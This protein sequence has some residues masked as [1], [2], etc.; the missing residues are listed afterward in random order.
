MTISDCADRSAQP[1]PRGW[2]LVV[3]DQPNV[4]RTLAAILESDGY[5]VRV[6]TEA[7]A[8]LDHLR[9][10]S[11]DVIL[12]ELHLG[13]LD[14]LTLL[15]EAR[16]R[17]PDTLAILTTGQASVESAVQALRGGAYDYLPKPSPVDELRATVARAMEQRH[18]QR[19]IEARVQDLER[20]NATVRALNA[21]LE[22]R[23][24][25]ATT[26]LEGRL[27]ALRMLSEATA[28]LASSLEYHA[29]LQR[30]VRVAV[31]F[32]ADWS[33]FDLVDD[34]GSARG[35]AVAHADPAREPSL[36][37]IQRLYPPDTHGPQPVSEVLR[38]G[39]SVLLAEVSEPVLRETS[40]D[41]KHLALRRR[42]GFRSV[43]VVPL[44]GRERLL[45]A[46]T[47][48]RGGSRARF[49]DDDRLL[50]E[51]L[52]HRCATALD[53][54]RLYE[55]VRRHAEH[56]EVLA[57]SAQAFAASLEL[58]DVLA[59][60]ARAGVEHLGDGCLVR[61]NSDGD[62]HWLQA[63]AIEH[64]NPHRQALAREVLGGAPARLGEGLSGTVAETGRPLL[65]NDLRSREPPAPLNVPSGDAWQRLSA[66]SLLIVP[67]RNK[68]GVIGTLET[69]RD[70]SSAPYTTD[71]QTFL[72]ALADRAALA[73]TN[74]RLHAE[75]E[76]ALHMRDEF[77]AIAA[78]ELKTPLTALTAAAQLSLR[79]FHGPSLPEVGQL[80]A[81]LTTIE[82]QARRFGA[83]VDRLLQVSTLESAPLMLRRRPTDVVQLVRRGLERAQPR[84]DR[85][86]VV[87]RAP[88]RVVVEMD[89][90]WM[91]RVVMNLVEN[92]LKYSAPAGTVEIDIEPR[93]AGEVEIAVRDHGRGI[94][95]ERRGHL[96]ERYYR[97]HADDYAS[98]LGLGLSI[99]R[100][101]VRHHGGHL[102]A[103][104]PPDGGSRFI[105]VLPGR[106]GSGASAARA[107]AR[108]RGRL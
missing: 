102:R 42:V 13:E 95:P 68:D 53:N 98:G 16:R 39:R 12:A 48:V 84:I 90:A 18:L 34:D 3:D 40:R 66:H 88:G 91:Q 17:A 23:V 29:T 47:L 38:T 54:A 64:P 61:L 97:A 19:E 101:I 63:A 28:V 92:A 14:G 105:V 78:H 24:Q 80:R 7:H 58:P 104:F 67:L 100:D 45:G 87:V 15:R 41:Q 65:V 62:E 2:V 11:F 32:L 30:V 55:A 72:Q 9:T 81:R 31:P 22:D 46:M 33:S 5:A 108:A 27:D 96:F 74:A 49:T 106:A 85:A 50:A 107:G 69:W 35:V 20:A 51:E 1:T 59:G 37:K 4:A 103:E 56:L 10:R 94:S 76:Q 75:T 71:D 43:L 21:D 99:S 60:T 8:A 77:V 26:A 86:R 44:H 83:L 57:G 6:A 70:V 25:R 93:K 89:P 52:A 73:I 82:Q 36:R 79:Q